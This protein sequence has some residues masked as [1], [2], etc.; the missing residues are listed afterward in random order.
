MPSLPPKSPLRLLPSTSLVLTSPWTMQASWLRKA[1][2]MLTSKKRR[3]R[4]R[5]QNLSDIQHRS[6]VVTESESANLRRKSSLQGSKLP[7]KKMVMPVQSSRR[8]LASA[9]VERPEAEMQT[10]RRKTKTR[11]TRMRRILVMLF[12]ISSKITSG[13]QTKRTTPGTT[14]RHTTARGKRKSASERRSMSS[15]SGRNRRST[16]ANSLK[17]EKKVS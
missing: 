13:E 15:Q 9:P 3:S 6:M 12:G 17:S 11:R 2:P 4:R 10:M 14:G 1:I 7:L 8:Q 5:L 16:S